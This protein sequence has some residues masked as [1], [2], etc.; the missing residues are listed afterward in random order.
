M[1]TRRAHAGSRVG[2]SAAAATTSASV[3]LAGVPEA[4]KG[5]PRP[6]VERA[7]VEI[8]TGCIDFVRSRFVSSEGQIEQLTT[9]EAEVLAY[10]VER[11]GEAVGRDELLGAVWGHHALSLS[12][13]VDT[14]M[15][16]LRRKIDPDPE[17]PRVLFTVHG[18]GYRLVTASVEPHEPEPPRGGPTRRIWQ[19]DE[20]KVD[21][22]TGVIEG[23]A[24]RV[25]LTA[26]ERLLLEQLLR[27]RGRIVDADKLA[28]SVGIVGGKSALSNAIARLRG[29]LERDPGDPKLL[30]AVRGEG[31]RLDGPPLESLAATP[32]EHVRALQSL[33]R[34]V[35]LVLGMADCVVF[36]RERGLLRQVAAWGPKCDASGELRDPLLLRFGEGLVG[37]AAL[38]RRAICVDDVRSDPRYVLDAVQAESELSVPILKR[39]EVVG[40]LDSESTRPAAYDERSVQAFM[41]LAAIAAPAFE[42]PQEEP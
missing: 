29:K 25:L 37:H 30:I 8:A 17:H 26:R 42:S 20:R 33:V 9:R 40:V 36:R 38:E 41:M 18:H 23:P 16:R 3:T 31:Y 39:G 14:A 27:A 21:L 24:G 7:P 22:G 6:W 13:A 28:R 11:V 5:D 12:R 32:D 1:W 4:S 34:H 10:L 2:L 35:G 15:A 19:L